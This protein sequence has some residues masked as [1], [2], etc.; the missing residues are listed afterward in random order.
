MTQFTESVVENDALGWL[1][2]TGGASPTAPTS[3]E[4]AAAERRDYGEVVLAQL[5]HRAL[6]RFTPSLKHSRRPDV[7]LFLNGPPLA[8]VSARQ[9]GEGDADCT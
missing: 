5:L 8:W 9:F 1:E 6:A 2:A 7:V 3:R 4:A